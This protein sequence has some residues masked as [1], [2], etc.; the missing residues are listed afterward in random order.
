M[1]PDGPAASVDYRQSGGGSVVIETLFPGSSHEM[2]TMYTVDG[3]NLVAS[4]YCAMGNQPA[5]KLDLAASTADK[6]VFNFVNV[7]GKKGD[8]IHDGWIRFVGAN[9]V[10]AQW[11]SSDNEAKR[12]FLNRTK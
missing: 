5:M 1:T 11:N 2:I 12:F 3:N 8:H 7:R 10:Q 9:Q 4:H 6:L